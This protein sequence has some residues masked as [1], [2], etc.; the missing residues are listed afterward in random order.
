MSDPISSS[1][2][3]ND[4]INSNEPDFVAQLGR[5]SGKLLSENLIR[6]GIDL[7]VRNGDTDPDIFYIDVNNDRIGINITPTTDLDVAGKIYARSDWTAVGTTAT[8]DNIVFNSNGSVTSTFGAINIV[9]AAPASIEIGKSLTPVFEFKDNY[10][11]ANTTNSDIVVNPDGT[12]EVNIQKSTLIRGD[13]DVT[14]DINVDGNLLKKG[15]III[16]DQPLDVVVVQT[17]FTQSIIPGADAT[18]DLGSPS[19]FWDITWITG[20]LGADNANITQTIISEQLRMSGNTISTINSNDPIILDSDTGNITL[21][22]ININQNTIT[23]LP[24]TPLT[25]ISTG[26]GYVQFM[27]E[28]AFVIPTGTTAER[29]FT[30]VGETRWNT[31]LGYLEC[32]DGTVYLA[33]TGGGT[34]ITPA[35][36]QELSEIYTLIFG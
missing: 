1:P 28:N 31:D 4:P 9:P 15:N 27:D 10:I 30:E 8:F 11:R 14:G 24:N 33:A 25:L 23:N 34:V 21:E 32:Y 20:N 2:L 22:S 18:Y 12:G 36:Q 17:D 19:K 26:I 5:I 6:H 16:G 7:T 3:G 29:G 13:L 35:I